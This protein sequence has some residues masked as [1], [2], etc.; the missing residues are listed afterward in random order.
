MRIVAPVAGLQHCSWGF[1]AEMGVCVQTCD[2]LHASSVQ[3]LSSSHSESVVQFWI[4]IV[5]LTYSAIGMLV[6]GESGRPS[7]V[8]DPAPS[9]TIESV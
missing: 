6:G 4:V 7:T 3:T 9:G 5:A 2:A 8:L 1:H